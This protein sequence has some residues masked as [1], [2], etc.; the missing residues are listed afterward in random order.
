MAVCIHGWLDKNIYLSRP[1]VIDDLLH[2]RHTYL[3]E[4][5]RWASRSLWHSLPTTSALDKSSGIMISAKGR[6]LREKHPDWADSTVST[7]GYLIKIIFD[8]LVITHLVFTCVGFSS[9]GFPVDG[10]S[11]IEFSDNGFSNDGILMWTVVI[12]GVGAK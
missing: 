10:L 6:Y 12:I 3:Q 8:S 1:L 7:H 2:A 5:R 11:V 4:R 9:N